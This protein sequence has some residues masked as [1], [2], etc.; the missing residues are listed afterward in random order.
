MDTGAQ[1]ISVPGYGLDERSMCINVAW[2]SRVVH[3]AYD[4]WQPEA[5]KS[6]K[7]AEAISSWRAAHMAD[8]DTLPYVSTIEVI[9]V[10]Y[11]DPTTKKIVRRSVTGREFLTLLHIFAQ[12]SIVRVFGIDVKNML[13]IAVADSWTDGQPPIPHNVWRHNT[14]IVDIIREL[15][16]ADLRNGFNI[17]KLYKHIMK[18]EE[19]RPLTVL[20]AECEN[21]VDAQ[22][23]LVCGIVRRAR[24]AHAPLPQC[25]DQEPVY[26]H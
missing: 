13:Q 7:T 23:S 26:D 1:A 18:V 12:G 10:E 17:Y 22:L 16:P 9:L 6:Y 24:L 5:P 11:D 4:M 20:T 19:P 21:N 25:F 3:E 2:R 15:L 14:V 8:V